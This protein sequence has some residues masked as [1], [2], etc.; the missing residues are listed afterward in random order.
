MT[1]KKGKQAKDRIPNYV[2][3]EAKKA[4]AAEKKQKKKD[5]N[6]MKNL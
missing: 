2:K 5:I 4:K 1:K 3:E 6:L